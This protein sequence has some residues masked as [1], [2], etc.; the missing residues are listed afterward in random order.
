MTKV[1]TVICIA[2]IIGI[3]TAIFTPNPEARAADIPVTVTIPEEDNYAIFV[4][5]GYEGVVV[6]SQ[7]LPDEKVF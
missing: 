2:C 3:L 7:A 6:A 4:P 1:L 5:N